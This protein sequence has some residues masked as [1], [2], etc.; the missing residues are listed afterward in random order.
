MQRCM[1]LP[2]S[3]GEKGGWVRL[4]CRLVVAPRPYASPSR[5]SALS[6]SE[7]SGRRVNCNLLSVICAIQHGSYQAWVPTEYECDWCKAGQCLKFYFILFL[8]HLFG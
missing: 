4:G 1:W 8:I 3:C 2:A 6:T 7:L 5:F